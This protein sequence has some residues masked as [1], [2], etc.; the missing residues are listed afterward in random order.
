MNDDQLKGKMDQLKGGIKQG[1]G[2]AMG[3]KRTER[4][5]TADRVGGKVQETIGKVKEKL[6]GDKPQGGDPL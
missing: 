5:G 3:D 4:E 2:G 6:Q 1:V